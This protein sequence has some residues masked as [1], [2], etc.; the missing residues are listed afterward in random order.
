MYTESEFMDMSVASRMARI[1]EEVN[2]LTLWLL[3]F[4]LH[5]PLRHRSFIK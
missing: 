2:K 1:N 3:L 5:I 4:K